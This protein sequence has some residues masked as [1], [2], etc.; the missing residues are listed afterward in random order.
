M[1]LA[2]GILGFLLITWFVF[3]KKH[4]MAKRKRRFL[5]GSRPW[6]IEIENEDER[7]LQ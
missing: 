2:L 1:E 3:H 5:P 4:E 6:W 7:D